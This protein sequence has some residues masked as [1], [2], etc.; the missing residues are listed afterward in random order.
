MGLDGLP[1]AAGIP[2]RAGEHVSFFS[3]FYNLIYELWKY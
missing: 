3:H 2:G 1:G